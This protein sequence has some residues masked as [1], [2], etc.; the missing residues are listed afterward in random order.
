MTTHHSSA[1]DLDFSTVLRA[2]DGLVWG[3]ACAEPTALVRRLMGQAA[4]LPDVTA[5]VGI[6]GSGT[7]A[8][9]GPGNVRFMSYTGSG[10]N[11]RLHQEGSLDILP[12]NYSALPRLLST[13][14]IRADVVL[15]Q[16]PPPDDGG[17]FSLGTAH[18]YL[19][20]ALDMAREII[21]EVNPRTPWVCGER[22]IHESQISQILHTPGDVPAVGFP[23]PDE[24]QSAVAEKAAALVENGSTLQ[25]GIGRLPN[26][27]VAQLKD[28]SGLGVH[29]GNIGDAVADLMESGAID[30]SRK[31]IDVGLT[32]TGAI[33]GGPRLM[34]FVHQNSG[35][36]LRS[37]AYTHDPAVLARQPNLISINSAL[38][39]D[40]S[41]QVNSESVAGRYLG[42]VGGSLDFTLAANRSPGGFPIV[43]LAS[44]ARG[45]SRIVKRLNGPVTIPRSEVGIIV[46]EHGYADL[47]GLTLDQRR[48]R[49]LAIC[50]PALRE[51]L[52]SE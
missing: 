49:L 17:Y 22:V 18:E 3:Q 4:A 6:P 31:T 40:L 52:E 41:G 37:T 2:G 51:T 16:L 10:I 13:G 30:G 23:A 43:A 8:E 35:I 26:A 28:R 34:S 46:T 11:A 50:D 48:E 7:I 15:L 25:I 24:I 14:I 38:E 1:E 33:I 20:A 27:V 29:S 36:S 47:R 44:S 5:F 39:V 45:V 9:S 32:V 12:A 42:A 21:V 19:G